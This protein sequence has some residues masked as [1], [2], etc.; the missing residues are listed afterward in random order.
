MN[1]EKEEAHA[2]SK[3]RKLDSDIREGGSRFWFF[4]TVIIRSRRI[5]VVLGCLLSMGIVVKTLLS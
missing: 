1:S 3:Q 5:Y 4:E 2:N